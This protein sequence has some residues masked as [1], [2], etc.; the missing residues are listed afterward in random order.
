MRI[1]RRPSINEVVQDKDV[2]DQLRDPIE[3]IACGNHTHP[4][5][6]HDREVVAIGQMHRL[7][8]AQAGRA[9]SVNAGE[10]LHRRPE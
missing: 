9:T 1:E 10:K 5:G 8:R 3:Q 4:L 6:R 2:V 7:E